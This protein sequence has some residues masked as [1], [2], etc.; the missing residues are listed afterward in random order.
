MYLFPPIGTFILNSAVDESI[1]ELV[2]EL[3]P[4]KINLESLKLC[5]NIMLI[6]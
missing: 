5:L 3:L 1:N 4:S 6:S 2:Y